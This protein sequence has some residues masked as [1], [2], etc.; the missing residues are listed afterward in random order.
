MGG[1]EEAGKKDGVEK[2]RRLIVEENL[3]ETCYCQPGKEYTLLK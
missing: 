3:E 2:D 1:E